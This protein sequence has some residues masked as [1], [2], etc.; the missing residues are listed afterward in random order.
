MKYTIDTINGTRD[1]LVAS[2]GLHWFG[3]RDEDIAS[4]LDVRARARAAHADSAPARVTRLDEHGGGA[5]V[6][7]GGS[8]HVTVPGVRYKLDANDPALKSDE[9]IYAAHEVRMRKIY[10]DARKGVSEVDS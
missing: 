5:L 10:T 3:A 6:A 9:D 4:Y 2:E 7:R 1:A 8:G